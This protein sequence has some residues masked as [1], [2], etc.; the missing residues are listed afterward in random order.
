MSGHPRTVD[1]TQWDEASVLHADIATAVMSRPLG[2]LLDDA[3]GRTP[4][5]VAVSDGHRQLTYAELS[6]LSGRF[7][8]WMLGFGLR[9]GDRVVVR[10]EPTVAFVVAL[11]AALRCAVTLVPVHPGHTRHELAAVVT[12]AEPAL[13]LHGTDETA[14]GTVAR[15]VTLTAAL[16]SAAGTALRLVPGPEPTGPAFLLYTSGS[17]GR[18]K[19]V[20]CDHDQVRAAL[21]GIAH[22]LRYRADD[23]VFCRIPLAFDYGLYQVLLTAAAGSHLVLAPGDTTVDLTALL[24]RSRATVL[25]VVPT[26]ARM[27][28]A[29]SRRGPD[30]S[31]V[32]LVTSTGERLTHED[33]RAL[34]EALP[35]AELSLMYGLTECKRVTV[36]PPTRHALPSDT[37]GFP[38]PG[39]RVAVLDTAGEVVPCGEI[40]EIVTTGPH[41]TSGYWRSP[42]S[43]DRCFARCRGTGRPVL[44]T[45]DFGHTTPEGELVVLGR[46]DDQ[47]KAAGMRV[48]GAEV[49]TAATGIPGVGD[50]V[51]VPPAGGRGAV[52]WVA[53]PL[54]PD[55]VVAG[56]HRLLDPAK[57][58][59]EVRVVPSLPTTANGKLDR[60]RVRAWTGEDRG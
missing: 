37:V 16:E 13:V 19:G 20:V 29:L 23:V 8:E 24:S 10:A 44:F 57:V 38:I 42:E 55:Q 35:C 17:S 7:A 45:G 11:H 43:T 25:P 2:T 27:I 54:A 15:A 1:T 60:A 6:E 58:P 9:P 39:T 21:G 41:V 3:A 14:P 59:R 12:D 28:L 40:G 32:R 52:L 49:E 31:H 53:T 22:R 36:R 56:L 34:L 47:Y 46:H 4:S 18:P 50:A 30:L 26:L 5:A 48:S 51:L 33:Q